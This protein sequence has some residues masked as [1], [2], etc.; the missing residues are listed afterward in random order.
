MEP[1][2]IS[3]Y[4]YVKSLADKKFESPTSIYKSSWIIREY[5]KRGGGFIYWFK[6]IFCIKKMV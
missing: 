2:D 3:L 5:K 4:K 1:K 6:K